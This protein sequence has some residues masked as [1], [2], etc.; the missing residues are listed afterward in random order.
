MNIYDYAPKHINLAEVSKQA[1]TYEGTFKELANLVKEKKVTLVTDNAGYVTGI[2]VSAHQD[3][4]LDEIAG[5]NFARAY[6]CKPVMDWIKIIIDANYAGTE[7]E[8]PTQERAHSEGDEYNLPDSVEIDIDDLEDVSLKS[9]RKYLKR[10]YG[11]CLAKGHQP[12]IT[13]EDDIVYVDDIEW[14]RKLSDSEM[15]DL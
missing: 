8:E 12:S 1:A 10:E 9:V 14:G 2:Y 6:G 15:E 4:M 13:E 5:Q 11:Y 3:T 7:P